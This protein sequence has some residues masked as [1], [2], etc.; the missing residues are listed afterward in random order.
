M[1]GVAG[2]MNKLRD[3][4]TGQYIS[5]KKVPEVDAN[6]VID[7]WFSEEKKERDALSQARAVSELILI[8]TTTIGIM[9]WIFLKVVGQ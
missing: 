3:K 1:R 9:L 6:K 5:A 2:N 7:I 4:K 8:L